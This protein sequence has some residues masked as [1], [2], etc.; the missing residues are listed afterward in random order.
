MRPIFVYAHGWEVAFASKLPLGAA[1]LDEAGHHIF[2]SEDITAACCPR[3]AVLFCERSNGGRA[4]VAPDAA[5]RM[6]D[7]CRCAACWRRRVAPRRDLTLGA[8]RRCAAQQGGY[9]R[10]SGGL[11]PSAAR[12]ANAARSNCCGWPGSGGLLALGV[13]PPSNPL[14][15]WRG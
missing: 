2:L 6:L 1:I 10:V 13:E 11:W 9:M 4:S 7:A 12:G 8:M 15:Q 14:A 3:S 5:R